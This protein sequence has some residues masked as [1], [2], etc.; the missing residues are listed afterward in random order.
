MKKANLLVASVALLIVTLC[1]CDALLSTNDQKIIGTWHASYILELTYVF[2]AD[3]TVSMTS[4]A[5]NN[6]GTWSFSGD[7]LNMV[8]EDT[9]S[10]VIVSF[11]NGTMTW[12]PTAG[13]MSITLVKQ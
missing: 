10:S 2:K 9:T 12:V 8:S 4:S 13:G 5:N 11:G 3:N 6:N 7:V 1:G